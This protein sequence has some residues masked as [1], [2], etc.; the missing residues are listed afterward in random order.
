MCAPYA[1]YIPIAVITILNGDVN[2]GIGLLAYGLVTGSILD[3]ILRPYLAG[4]HADAHPLLI[5]LGV[6]GGLILL[7]PAGIIV[8]PV[9]LL[10]AVT[11]LK[12]ANLAVW[13]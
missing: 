5:L 1:L 4:K 3:Y 10:G 7:G 2:A 6:L 12:S 11:V 8:G 13:K 9:I